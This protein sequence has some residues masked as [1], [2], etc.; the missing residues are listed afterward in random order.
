VALLATI[1]GIGEPTSQKNPRQLDY[2]FNFISPT[3]LFIYFLIYILASFTYPSSSK[4]SGLI[5]LPCHLSH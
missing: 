2:K 1:S 4:E 5:L 3:L